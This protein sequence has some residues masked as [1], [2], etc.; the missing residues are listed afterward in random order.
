[1]HTSYTD[2]DDLDDEPVIFS[3]EDPHDVRKN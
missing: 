1:M 3:D 2:T